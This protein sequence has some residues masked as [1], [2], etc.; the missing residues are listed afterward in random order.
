MPASY[1]LALQIF[2]IFI[3]NR[4]T[5]L[6]DQTVCGSIEFIFAFYRQLSLT[7]FK[8]FMDAILCI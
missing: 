2:F 5:L 6:D 3:V 4:I 7:V 8:N 1:A